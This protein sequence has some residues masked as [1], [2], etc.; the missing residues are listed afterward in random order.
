M[1]TGNCVYIKFR[2]LYPRD[3]YIVIDLPIAFPYIARITGYFKVIDE[4]KSAIN[5]EFFGFIWLILQWCSC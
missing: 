1:I 3:F 5:P 2:I 4:T